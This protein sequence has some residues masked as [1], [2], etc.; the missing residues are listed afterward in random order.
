MPRSTTR[1]VRGRLAL[2]Q[3]TSHASSS[4]RDVTHGP[5]HA[6]TQGPGPTLASTNA[7]EHGRRTHGG[8][9]GSSRAGYSGRGDNVP[10]S[11]QIKH[12]R[13]TESLS[14]LQDTHT[15][16]SDTLATLAVHKRKVADVRVWLTEALD[17]TPT[18][19]K[20][21]AEPE[22]SVTPFFSVVD[23][24]SAFLQSVLRFAPLPLAS[25]DSNRSWRARSTASVSLTEK[26]NDE[27][28]RH[29][30]R[31]IILVEDWPNLT[32]ERTREG[33]HRAL[34]RFIHSAGQVPLVLIVSDTV[35]RADTDANANDTFS[36]RS[37]RAVQ[38]NIRMA[39]PESVR[40]HPALTEIRF[41]PLTTRMILGALTAQA[42]S[43]IPRHVLNAIAE[44]AGGDIRSATNA[45][46][47][48]KN[49]PPNNVCH[50][51]AAALGNESESALVLF[52]ALGRVL[53][54]KRAGDA[55]ETLDAKTAAAGSM[56]DKMSLDICATST[57]ESSIP[58]S[59]PPPPPWLVHQRPSL[60][61]IET[62]W[63]HLP[64][65]A[66]TFQLYLHHNMLAFMD[67][68]DEALLA[69]E[70]MSFADTFC[71]KCA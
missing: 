44:A 39:V 8:N 46:A 60:V 5:E 25:R 41:N 65:D 56:G 40:M 62:L 43:H 71:R 63:S 52:H 45:V 20:Y 37:R 27:Q 59:S 48:L 22:Q 38:M 35:P 2:V 42:P 55:G 34:E 11:M 26:S 28:K 18:L 33:V 19:A 64:V 69:L 3:R 4:A 16:P 51:S 53:Y 24:F 58:E 70:A 1:D 17:G 23:R 10:T 61:N 14:S 31:R 66:T 9:H 47:M 13:P 7:R 6:P 29:R 21:R 32:H 68:T 54:N 67:D 50:E 57:E 36:W 15:H 12:T 30:Q 49:V